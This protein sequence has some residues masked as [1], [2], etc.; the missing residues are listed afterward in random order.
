M[1]RDVREDEEVVR[2]IFPMFIVMR[3]YIEDKIYFSLIG[4]EEG[5]GQELNLYYA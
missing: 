5:I 3:Q 2:R 4:I 1:E